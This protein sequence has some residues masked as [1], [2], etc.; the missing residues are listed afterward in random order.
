MFRNTRA[1]AFTRQ[2][3]KRNFTW[4]TRRIHLRNISAFLCRL[5]FWLA[6]KLKV[7]CIA[8]RAPDRC[9]LLQILR[10]CKN[11]LCFQKVVRLFNLM[12]DY[13]PIRDS[14]RFEYVKKC[15]KRSIKILDFFKH[16]LI[17]T[18]C[19][20]PCMFELTDLYYI[21]LISIILS[22]RCFVFKIFYFLQNWSIKLRIIYVFD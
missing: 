20:V 21:N 5:K 1:F 2:H 10:P 22:S 11:S 16:R 7:N 17:L 8:Q 4:S 19:L 15:F 13:F 3:V 6:K 9:K 14:K 12:Q 18:T